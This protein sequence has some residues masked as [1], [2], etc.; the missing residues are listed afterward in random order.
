[1]TDV[2]VA[3]RYWHRLLESRPTPGQPLAG[4]G[5]AG[6]SFWQRFWASFIGVALPVV[7]DTDDARSRA[8]SAVPSQ[9]VRR[10]PT[11]VRVAGGWLLLP[12][13]RGLAILRASDESRVVA[14]A[15][16]P[17]GRTEF[18]VRRDRTAQRYLLEVVLRE[19]DQLPV[20]FLVRYE[21]ARGQQLLAVPLTASSIGPPSAYVELADMDVSQRWAA[22]GP[23]SGDQAT[24]WDAGV[25]AASVAAAA[26]EATREAWRQVS[27]MLGPDLHQVID[28]ALS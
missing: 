8:R 6:Y 24:A 2:P 22:L 20:F 9:P 13:L 1:M 23:L 4:R 17:D 16:A 28:Q 15:A 18:F 25:V 12:E 11:T 10:M 7:A 19:P 27:G 14:E 26:S 3:R 21:T 5:R